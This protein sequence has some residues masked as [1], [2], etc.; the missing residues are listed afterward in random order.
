MRRDTKVFGTIE[1]RPGCL[2]PACSP[3]C[4]TAMLDYCAATDAG[5]TCGCICL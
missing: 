5:C 1:L 4:D 2:E 3:L